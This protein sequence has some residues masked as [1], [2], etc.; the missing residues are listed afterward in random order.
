[1]RC[2]LLVSAG[3]KPA[4]SERA[5]LSLAQQLPR[6]GWEPVCV[7]LEDGPLREW[8]GDGAI[9]LE[10]GRT[11]QLRRTAATIRELARLAREHDVDALV[12][13]QSKC[14]V[15]GGI[16]ALRA[17]VPAVW[18]QHGIPGRTRIELAAA[19]IP[20]ATVVCVS[21]AAVSAQRAITPGRPVVVVHPGVPVDAVAAAAGSGAELR[22]ALGW[23][24][25]KVAGIVGRLQPWKGQETFLEAA[26]LLAERR[27][28]LRYA[29]V[30]GAIL[31]REGDY[32]ERLQQ[33]ARELGLEQRVHF[34]GHQD[35]VRPW[36]D[37]FDV[38]VHASSAE[39]FGLVVVEA[40]A[41]GTPVVAAAEGGAAEIVEHERS[42][43]LVPPRDAQALADAVER[44]A[45]DSS[46]AERLGAGGRE[47]AR[48]FDES[49]SCA[50]FAAVLAHVSQRSA[51]PLV[52]AG[53]P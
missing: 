37:A 50:E 32:A 5:F 53:V 3:A 22:R 25:A 24:G 43:L 2:V 18:W 44:I 46:L 16:A 8:L 17:G 4:G 48:V 49:G 27:P 13:S 26:A 39:P 36:F 7:L 45:S 40:M 38:A 11:R 33:R 29:V 47:R 42:G 23:D 20:A 9:V 35:D 21:E 51:A 6:H 15:Y 28:E 31:G 10:A 52:E 19:R 34:A 1:M 30:G 12:S 14:H 41:L